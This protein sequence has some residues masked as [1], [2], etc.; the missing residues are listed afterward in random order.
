[1][2]HL[3]GEVDY[4][5][6]FT[7]N[8]EYSFIYVGIQHLA[9]VNGVIGGSGKKFYYHNDHLGSA[10]ALTDEYGN[11]VVER[12][13]TPFGE[14]INTDV[15]DDEPRDLDEDESGFTGKDWDEDVGL[16]YYNAR[17]YDPEVGRFISEDSVADDP[18]LYGYC[19]NNPVNF[20]DPTG[21]AAEGGFKVSFK[22]DWG[23]VGASLNA[24]AILSGDKVMGGISSAFS[25]FVTI[26]E[27]YFKP[28]Q[29]EGIAE[30]ANINAPINGPV[31][32]AEDSNNQGGDQETGEGESSSQTK[33]PSQEDTTS[34]IVE[35]ALAEA[36]AIIAMN[37]M[38][39]HEFIQEIEKPKT[40]GDPSD[41]L[42]EGMDYSFKNY[43]DTPFGESF[44]DGTYT[45]S[46]NVKFPIKGN[47]LITDGYGWRFIFGKVSFHPGIDIGVKE[48]PVFLPA[49][50]RILY[51]GSTSG[52]WGNLVVV[53]HGRNPLT[54]NR[55]YTMYE[56]NSKL[57][58]RA[59]TK[60]WLEAG[61]KISISGNTGTSTG[62]HL[63]YTI[64]EVPY[65]V[66]YSDI[67][68]ISK[69]NC[70]VVTDLR[71]RFSV[72]PLFYKW[73]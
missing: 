52:G 5:K 17:W 58:V 27:K 53:D 43:S 61:T 36:K 33:S 2:P 29:A 64:L 16:Y 25:L 56:H 1:M 23:F 9:R 70:Q 72:N 7:T 63:H 15:Y 59:N 20:T 50:G 31:E 21:H 57:L 60:L 26:Y 42:W 37:D 45:S 14:R 41:L 62:Y 51:A 44:G 6:E 3:N 69:N 67:F 10:L 46:Y 11:K 12:D 35:D 39:L 48:V 65:G 30:D 66:S 55:V 13:F 18:N 40:L 24:V 32:D 68:I 47:F 73:W 28:E 54:G 49:R 19:F 4:R 8:A 38:K 71:N 34:K 22:K